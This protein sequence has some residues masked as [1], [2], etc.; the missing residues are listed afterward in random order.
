MSVREELE[1]KVKEQGAE[2]L[3]AAEDAAIY[4]GLLAFTKER[5]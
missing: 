3:S 4:H 2:S 5:L 1:Q